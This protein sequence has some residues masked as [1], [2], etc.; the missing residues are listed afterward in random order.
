V[1]APSSYIT[2]VGQEEEVAEIDTGDTAWMMI[3]AA[4]VL[5]MT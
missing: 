1:T 2:G 3:S 5:L 4:I